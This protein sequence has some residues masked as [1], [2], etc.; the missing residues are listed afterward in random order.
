M[1]VSAVEVVVVG[2]G[3]ATVAVSVEGFSR[4]GVDLWVLSVTRPLDFSV[5][6]VLV[7]GG[8]VDFPESAVGLLEGVVSLHDV[9]VSALVLALDVVSVWVVYAVF[10]V[11]GGIVVL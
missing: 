2:G 3:S 9:S 8:V 6:S 10:E 4:A 11:V 5:E 7:V 1:V